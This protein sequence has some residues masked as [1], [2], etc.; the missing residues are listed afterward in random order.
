RHS[1]SCTGAPRLDTRSEMNKTYLRYELSETF[2][3]VASPQSNVVYDST[4]N[5]AI[6]AALH[7]VAVWNLRQC[8]LVRLLSPEGESAASRAQVTSLL[9]SPD[10]STVAAGYSSGLVLLF[11]LKT[12]ATAVT[13]HGH[14]SAVTAARYHASGALLASGSADTDIVVWDAVAE[15]G[16]Y[17]LR[18]HRDGVTDVVFLGGEGG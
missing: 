1:A 9:L 16:L 8:S 13:L 11:S 15:S 18:G 10:G 7:E 3:V 14:R 5:L 4:G 12:G 6:S 2:G 17:R